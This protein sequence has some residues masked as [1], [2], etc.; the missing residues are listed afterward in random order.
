M[1]FD[2]ID[3][4]TTP[5]S[6]PQAML[7]GVPDGGCVSY[8]MSPQSLFLIAASFVTAIFLLRWIVVRLI[9]GTGKTTSL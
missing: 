2:V 1:D 9:R 4:C 3:I 6:P 7:F 8:I 5:V